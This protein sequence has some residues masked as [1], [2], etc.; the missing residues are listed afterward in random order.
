MG[1]NQY[2]LYWSL[3]NTPDSWKFVFRSVPSC[4]CPDPSLVSNS[5]GNRDTDNVSFFLLHF[6][7]ILHFSFL[8]DVT[9]R[10]T[11]TESGSIFMCAPFFHSFHFIHR[12]CCTLRHR[13]D[14]VSWKHIHDVRGRGGEVHMALTASCLKTAL[15][16]YQLQS[17]KNSALLF[18]Y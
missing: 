8:L 17:A 6:V 10:R 1:I 9:R 3:Q 16:R 12:P 11:Q 5:S 2:A 13:P 14:L 4:Q 15:S 18:S 7:V